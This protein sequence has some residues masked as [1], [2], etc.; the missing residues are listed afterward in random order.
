M[1]A[2]Q[3]SRVQSSLASSP[4]KEF[5]RRLG[6]SPA[7]YSVRRIPRSVVSIDPSSRVCQ[8]PA[9]WRS[10][11]ISSF[12]FGKWHQGVQN[13]VAKTSLLQTGQSSFAVNGVMVVM[14]AEQDKPASTW[15][16]QQLQGRGETP[17]KT[18]QLTRQFDSYCCRS[19]KRLLLA[20]H[21]MKTFS[22]KGR[23]DV[24]EDAVLSAILVTTYMPPSRVL[25]L[26]GWLSL[27]GAGCSPVAFAG[28]HSRIR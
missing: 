11:G 5:R 13:A 10:L 22:E 20:Q 23:P 17:P 2:W 16:S 28:G 24:P 27:L 9:A 12:S 14:S 8:L 25:P 3:L 4:A 6:L 21:N 18:S 26:L 1:V 19:M 7:R 15:Q